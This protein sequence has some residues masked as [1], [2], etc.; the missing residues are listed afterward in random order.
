M[1]LDLPAV[2]VMLS[3]S[4]HAPLPVPTIASERASFSVWL[5]ARLP[6]FPQH[7]RKAPIRVMFTCF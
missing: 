1:F 7:C 5:F 2:H 6:S 3:H 4:T